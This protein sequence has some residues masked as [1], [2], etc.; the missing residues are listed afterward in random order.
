MVER[1]ADQLAEDTV[2]AIQ[3]APTL[4]LAFDDKAVFS[5]ALAGARLR[6]AR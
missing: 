6:L 5:R 1:K 4:S 2:A 3:G